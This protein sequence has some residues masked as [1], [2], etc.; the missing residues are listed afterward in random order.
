MLCDTLMR[1]DIHKESLVSNVKNKCQI[2]FISPYK[3]LTQLFLNTAKNFDC[4]INVIEGAFDSVANEIASLPDDVDI[5]ISRGGTAG[6][7]SKYTIKPVVSIK[8]SVID[9][10]ATLIPY[11][12]KYK[13]IAIISYHNKII[14]VDVVSDA[15]NID[16]QQYIF[17]ERADI[18]SILYNI[19]KDV[20]LVIGGVLI[21]HTADMF[22]IPFQIFEAGADAIYNALQEAMDIFSADLDSRKKAAQLNTIFSTLT[23][24]V[25]VTDVND[26]VTLI[27][28]VALEILNCNI[29]NVIGS[30]ILDVVPSSLTMQVLKTKNKHSG[31]LIDI[32][33]VTYISNRTPIIN[34]DIPVGVVCV[35]SEA[36][37][38]IKA[39]HRLRRKEASS[40]GFISRYKFDSII[41]QNESMLELIELCK[42]YSKT[43]ANILIYGESGTGK[44]L[45]A[46]S[47]H[48]HSNRSEFPFIAIN[49]AAIPENLLES[50]LFGY[51]DGAFTGASRKG[52]AGLFE[53]AHNGTLFLDEISELPLLMQG[54]LLRVLQEKEI[55][56]VG[57]NEIIPVNVR[58]I[59]ATNRKLT[60][61]ISSGE[62]RRDLYFRLNILNITIPPLNKRMDDIPLLLTAFLRSYNCILSPKEILSVEQVLRDHNY[63]GNI[64][65]F[66]SIVERFSIL[67]TVFQPSDINEFMRDYCLECEEENK[68]VAHHNHSNQLVIQLPMLDDFKSM[69][70]Y[71]Q[72]KIIEHSV[73]Q[74]NNDVASTAEVLKISKMTLWRHLHEGFVE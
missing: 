37:A 63:M 74:N 73:E 51:A 48:Q 35:I 46:Q 65:E 7:I 41:T 52:K 3:K 40:R 34:N 69:T 33:N 12:G 20:D 36:D 14:G 66:K 64:R 28:N 72:R 13:K 1:I 26:K 55:L 24:G 43:N 53:I 32:N 17:H 42:Y 56:R 54:K 67:Y 57:S 50:E 70:K 49:C 44:E 9:L 60:E 58:I 5:I 31:Q 8:A 19:Y 71:C 61:Q 6:V 38:I 10:L 2:V 39:G 45:F 30:N 21:A 47:I 22:N 23:E 25:I 15:L 29:D 59:A 68:P 11:K 4:S 18:Y 62:F 27:N 16:I